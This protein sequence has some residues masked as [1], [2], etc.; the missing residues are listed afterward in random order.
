V[1]QLAVN[2]KYI[3]DMEIARTERFHDILY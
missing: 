1:E 3:K 2:Y